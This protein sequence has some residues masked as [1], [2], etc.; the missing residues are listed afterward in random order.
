MQGELRSLIA[1]SV[2]Y[3][4]MKWKSR[5]GSKKIILVLIFIGDYCSYCSV[6]PV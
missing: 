2:L 3:F 6:V 4:S 1:F 5:H